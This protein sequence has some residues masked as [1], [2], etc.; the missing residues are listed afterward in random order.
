MTVIWTVNDVWSF[1]SESMFIFH[2][3]ISI[4]L[5]IEYGCVTINRFLSA[6]SCLFTSLL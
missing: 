5:F 1:G 6:K 2:N 4:G 3:W